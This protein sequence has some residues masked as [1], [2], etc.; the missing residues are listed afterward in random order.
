[1]ATHY[2]GQ[3]LAQ[4]ARAFGSPPRIAPITVHNGLGPES[5]DQLHDAGLTMMEISNL[6]ISERKLN[7]YKEHGGLLSPEESERVTSILRVVEQAKNIFHSKEKALLWLRT[8]DERHQDISPLYMLRNEAGDKQVE[9][10]LWQ[11]DEGIYS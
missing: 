3:I 2:I 4:I 1:M 7:R 8:P 6:V 10:M 9:A 11:I 5:V